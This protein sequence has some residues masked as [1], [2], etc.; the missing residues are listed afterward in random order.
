ML[1]ACALAEEESLPP[2]AV[3]AQPVIY[4]ED[5]RREVQDLE[6]DD[7]RSL[8]MTAVVAIVPRELLRFEG[9]VVALEAPT[10]GD[11]NGLCPGERFADQ[12]SAAVCSGMLL[13]D[14]LVLTAGHCMRR[15]QCSD[16]AFVFNY[17]TDGG[18]PRT[19]FDSHDVYDCDEVI[20]RQ[21]SVPSAEDRTDYAWVHLTRTAAEHVWPVT[22]RPASEP[23]VVGEPVIVAGFGGGLP[24]KVDLGGVVTD[25]RLDTGDYFLTT[26]DTFHGDS[27]APVLDEQLRLIGL[28]VRGGADYMESAA[29][30][31]LVA[32]L[33]DTKEAGAEQNTYFGRAIAGLCAA[34][35]SEAL[36]CSHA[37]CTREGGSQS[38]CHV[39]RLGTRAGPNSSTMTGP[40]AALAAW[41]AVLAFSRS[42]RRRSSQRGSPRAF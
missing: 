16:V 6:D 24:M 11:E 19:V 37:S 27:G 23:L 14:Q 15:L 2:L 30:C 32:R 41:L 34:N 10:F 13:D 35:P 3:T 31:N 5:G 12:P 22:A 39:T 7:L 28:Q 42:R 8:A 36:C 38:G 29:G 4:G 40:S 18:E 21:L 17:V 33:P 20:A 25:L 26:S 9:A 1:G